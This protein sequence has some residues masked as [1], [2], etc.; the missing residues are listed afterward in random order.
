M[1][2]EEHE[3]RLRDTGAD[4]VWRAVSEV[5]EFVA[6]EAAGEQDYVNRMNQQL[7]DRTQANHPRTV[8]HLVGRKRDLKTERLGWDLAVAFALCAAG[9]QPGPARGRVVKRCLDT[10][11]SA[12][13]AGHPRPAPDHRDFAAVA[14]NPR[15]LKLTTQEL[16][17]SA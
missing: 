4:G 2:D 11:E 13:L 16:R 6:E 10:L 3:Y 9:M 17:K 1:N 15:F 14:S 8:D 7:W 12:I 5:P